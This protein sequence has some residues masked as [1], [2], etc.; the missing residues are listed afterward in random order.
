MLTL[1]RAHAGP[2]W[3]FLLSHVQGDR[4]KANSLSVS[5]LMDREKNGITKSQVGFFDIVGESWMGHPG[6]F[7]GAFCIKGI[8]LSFPKA[9]KK[10][11]ASCSLLSAL[12]LS[13]P[14]T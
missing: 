3:S 7:P 12:S 14:R 9:Y 8:G 10:L 6:G 2:C 4:E 11:Q 5:P 13:P 1:L